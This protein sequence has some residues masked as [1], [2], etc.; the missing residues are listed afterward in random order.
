MKAEPAVLSQFFISCDGEGSSCFQ[1]FLSA[2]LEFPCSPG[3]LWAV[4]GSRCVLPAAAPSPRWV[5]GEKGRDA[6]QSPS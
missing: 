4:F 5:N 2:P 6:A 3:E 1:V